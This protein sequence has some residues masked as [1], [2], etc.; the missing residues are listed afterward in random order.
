MADFRGFVPTISPDAPIAQQILAQ[1]A[2]MRRDGSFVDGAS[3]CWDPA[4]LETLAMFAVGV[5]A[6]LK[7]FGRHLSHC[8]LR[9]RH[10]CSQVQ[11][12]NGRCPSWA[13]TRII[14]LTSTV[15]RCDDH[16]GKLVGER[17]ALEQPACTCGFAAALAKLSPEAVTPY[18]ERE[19]PIGGDN[20]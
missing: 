17:T 5:K 15:Y 20:G 13:T 7:T 1:V 14:T 11:G 2:N 4:Q 3:L 8:A 12:R 9:Q 6:D 16:H 10:V 18:S 19:T